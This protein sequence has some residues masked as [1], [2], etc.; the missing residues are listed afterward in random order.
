MEWNGWVV[1]AS[2]GCWTFSHGNHHIRVYVHHVRITQHISV[3]RATHINLSVC[4]GSWQCQLHLRLTMAAI[5]RSGCEWLCFECKNGHL[6]GISLV[7]HLWKFTESPY[8]LTFTEIHVFL[9]PKSTWKD[10]PWKPVQSS[11]KEGCVGSIIERGALSHII[12]V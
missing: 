1:G 9:N 6:L 4:S 5:G 12:L 8:E 3:R 2:W 7:D 11:S 10:Q